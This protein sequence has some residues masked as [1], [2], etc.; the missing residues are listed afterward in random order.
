[1]D[2]STRCNKC[3]SKIRAYIPWYYYIPWFFG[4]FFVFIAYLKYDPNLPLI[5]FVAM[6]LWGFASIPLGYLWFGKVAIDD[7]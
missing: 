7:E 2:L 3:G 5:A 6:L 4:P 1:M